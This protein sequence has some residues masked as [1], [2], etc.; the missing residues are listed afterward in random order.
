MM[1][2]MSTSNASLGTSSRLFDLSNTMI[3][4]PASAGGGVKPTEAHTVPVLPLASVT[5]TV[6]FPLPCGV[7]VTTDPEMVAVATEALFDCTVYGETPPPTV[8]VSG[9][10]VLSTK[11][12][13]CGATY[14]V[15]DTLIA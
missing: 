15:A 12:T 11:L 6:V 7:I 1:S 5:M 13:A 2:S 4:G 9:G 3:R 14:I 8:D 10:I